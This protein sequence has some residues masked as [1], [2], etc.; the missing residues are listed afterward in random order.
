MRR[1]VRGL[2]L[3]L[4]CAHASGHGASTQGHQASKAAARSGGFPA[5]P[6]GAR[7]WF[8]D[9]AGI[10]PGSGTFLDPYTDLAAALATPALAP[11]DQVLVAPG[12]YPGPAVA[13]PFGVRVVSTQGAALTA[14]DGQGLAPA[15][16]VAGT[17]GVPLYLE[18]FTLENGAGSAVSPI[19]SAGGGLQAV[20]ARFELEGRVGL[21]QNIGH[22]AF[23]HAS[24][25]GQ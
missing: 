22:H 11:G 12:V 1:A 15:L 3:I 13:P 7:T 9:A 10:P 17:D 8:V 14:I 2:A 16:R 19:F 4:A 25:H 21:R 5:V 23:G 24:K 6:W 20:K 18:G